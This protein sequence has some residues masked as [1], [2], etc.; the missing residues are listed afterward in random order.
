MHRWRMLSLHLMSDCTNC[1]TTCCRFVLRTHIKLQP[2]RF[3]LCV[4]FMTMRFIC[5]YF[6]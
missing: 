6:G 3:A 2:G 5:F 1:C 4:L